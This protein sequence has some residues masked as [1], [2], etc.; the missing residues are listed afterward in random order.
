MIRTLLQYFFNTAGVFFISVSL[1]AQ[2]STTYEQ[3][4]STFSNGSG[5]VSSAIYQLRGTLGQPVA[6]TI[7]SGS[8]RLS[9]GFV[10]TMLQA[11]PATQPTTIVFSSVSVSTL[12][13]SFT[14][15][16]NVEGYIVLR[17]A[18]SAPAGLPAD[19]VS[20]NAGNVIGD[21][22]AVLVGSST[23]FNDTGLSAGTVYHY[24]VY[25]FNGSVGTVNYLTTNP[26]RGEKVTIPS[27]PEWP[28]VLPLSNS[29]SSSFTATWN[30]T[31]GATGY[32]LDVS[33]QSNFSVFTSDYNGKSVS[34]TSSNITGL[35]PGTEYFVRVRAINASGESSNSEAKSITTQTSGGLNNQTITFNSLPLKIFGD[36]PF[37]LTATASS[38][39]TVTYASSNTN[40]ATIFGNT[41]TLTGFGTTVITASQA[42]NAAYNPAP[43]V[44]QTLL[45]RAAAPSS[46]PSDLLFSNVQTASMQISFT[47]PANPPSGYLVLRNTNAISDS[48]VDG[49]TYTVGVS[50]IGT[51]AVVY[52]GSGTSFTSGGLLAGSTYHYAVFAY[53]GTDVSTNYLEANP[54]TSSK[55][56]LAAPPLLTLSNPA[57]LQFVAEWN[58]VASATGY[59]LDVSANNAFSGF[60]GDFNGKPITGVTQTTVSGLQPS[61]EYFV[62]VRTVNPS[63]ESAHSE[64][65]SIS[66]TPAPPLTISDPLFAQSLP[67][68]VSVTLSNGY[69]DKTVKFFHRGILSD[70]FEPKTLSSATA[71]YSTVIESSMLD[72]IGVEFYFTAED[73]STSAPLRSPSDRNQPIYRQFAAS[74][75]SIPNLSFGGKPENYRIISIPYKLQDNNAGAVFST[76]GVFG[77][78]LRW[79]LVRYENGQNRNLQQLDK[80]IRGNGYWFNS[81]N[82]V[83][84]R[85]G[86]GESPNNN[87]SE[88]FR[89]DLEK[90]WNQIGD[91]YPFDINWNDVR[92]ANPGVAVS[93]L[94]VF[95]PSTFG[96]QQ[97]DDL[98]QWSGGFVFADNAAALQLPVTLKNSG[99]RKGSRNMSSRL[100]QDE[101]LV[102]LTLT[103]GPGRNEMIGVGMHPEAS[104]GKDAFDE[105][106]VP[107][108]IKYL[109][110]E[111]KH[112]EY[113]A[114]YFTRDVA[115][116]GDQY[117]WDFSVHSN[118]GE[119]EATLSWDNSGFGNN[120]S[121]LMLFHPD[122][123]LLVDMKQS[124]YYSFRIGKGTKLKVFYTSTRDWNPDFTMLGRP[125]PNPSASQITVPVVV[126]EGR[127]HIVVDIIDLL[128][129]PVSYV[130]DKDVEQGLHEITWD[131]LDHTSSKVPAGMY[132][133]RM[134][135]DRSRQ[136]WIQKVMIK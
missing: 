4:S 119:E 82:E 110:M 52:I 20:Y 39:L 118:M 83:T 132:L 113:F 25:A 100:D 34:S 61:T 73:A 6:G 29:T 75:H 96:F 74:D 17:K 48:P 104:I 91:P 117:T 15:A 36:P 95:E 51:S 46:Q 101:W 124:D 126:G 120:A 99:G 56:T 55:I 70:S 112:E 50:L 62:R 45:V 60:V 67:A 106:S 22:T 103:H 37:T 63:G 31:Q 57:P 24:V 123:Q 69:G 89:L 108:F 54:L 135:V 94:V 116:T 64:V 32:K 79:R 11:E 133:I 105:I 131:G 16:A 47:A 5:S 111:T 102:P 76:L 107:R 65:R 109:E 77:E 3:K 53:N 88:P 42:G 129:R 136:Q 134:T 92:E 12:Q 40:V 87:Q 66:T 27:A 80:I 23:T 84:I 7:S 86:P 115:P 49:T 130:L 68:S 43:D 44:Q 121:R 122:A 26:L 90:G 19:G 10:H 8:Y 98:K 78:N 13:G 30:P 18:T 127:T 71:T 35:Q 33:T 59:K 85:P 125:Y 14:P 1:F 72:D 38:G 41:V 58:A 128:G 114:P 9:A 21:A 81:V 2:T 93:R 97:S 28:S